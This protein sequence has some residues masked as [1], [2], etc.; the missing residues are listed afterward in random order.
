ATDCQTSCDTTGHCKASV[1]LNTVIGK[2]ADPHVAGTQ[3]TVLVV[4]SR[5]DGVFGRIW[6][7]DGTT[8]PSEISI[9]QGGSHP[10]VA[11][12]AGGFRVVY[13][14]S[15]QGDIDGVFLRTISLNGALAD[16]EQLVNTVTSGP[17]DQ[18]DVAAL[19]DGTTIVV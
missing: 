1:K 4:W 18:P 15:G 7:T 10:R 9:A 5:P 8:S 6:R 2:A 12:F 3:G 11:A 16:E 13:Q 17:Q 19:D 14:G